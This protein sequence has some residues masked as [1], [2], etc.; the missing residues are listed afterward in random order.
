MIVVADVVGTVLAKAKTVARGM[1]I[2][3]ATF[4]LEVC[5]EDMDDGKRR[6][7]GN[8]VSCIPLLEFLSGHMLP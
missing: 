8:C 3:H 2:S 4:Q 7:G 5:A 6:V 1:G